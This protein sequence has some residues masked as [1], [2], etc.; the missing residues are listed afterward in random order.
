M[1]GARLARGSRRG[2][3]L[4]VWEETIIAAPRVSAVLKYLV[5]A[6]RLERAVN[7]F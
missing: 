5:R 2:R 6:T 1:A 3:G 7:P 4:Q